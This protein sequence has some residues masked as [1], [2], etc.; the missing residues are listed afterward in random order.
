MREVRE[1][2]VQLRCWYKH[3]YRLVENKIKIEFT[4]YQIIMMVFH[5]PL[6]VLIAA[7]MQGLRTIHWMPLPWHQTGE[8]TP[9]TVFVVVVVVVGYSHFYLL[10][11][12]SGIL[13]AVVKTAQQQHYAICPR[14]CGLRPDLAHPLWMH[15]PPLV[16]TAGGGTDDDDDVD[17]QN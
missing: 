17:Y 3:Q 11:W 16:R 4:N 8:P 9:S 12:I 1:I 6:V 14:S 7:E 13:V 15:T 10:F 2:N 5:F